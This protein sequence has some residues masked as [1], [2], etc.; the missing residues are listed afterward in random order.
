M[1]LAYHSGFLFLLLLQLLTIT[2]SYFKS[3][4]VLLKECVS[5]FF[6]AGEFFREIVCCFSYLHFTCLKSLSDLFKLIPEMVEM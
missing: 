5:K 2:L 1:I 6:E 4:A 3:L